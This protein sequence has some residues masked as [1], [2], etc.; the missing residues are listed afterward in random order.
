[1]GFHNSLKAEQAVLNSL[2][3]DNDSLY[4]ISGFLTPEDFST[5][6]YGKMFARAKE[7]IP[8]SKPFDVATLSSEGFLLSEII[9]LHDIVPTAANV[10]HYASLVKDYSRRRSLLSVASHIE[11]L[12]ESGASA[13]D[14]VREAEREILSIRNSVGEQGRARS[15]KDLSTELMEV[16]KKRMEEGGGFFGHRTGLQ[17]LDSLLGGMQDGETLIL[18]GRPSMGK[19]SVATQII[20]NRAMEGGRC[21]FHSLEMSHSMCVMR[22]LAQLSSLSMSRIKNGNVRGDNFE[23][24]SSAKQLLSSFPIWIDDTGAISV[25]NIRATA[26]RIAAEAGGLDLLVVD[27]L[28]LCGGNGRDGRERD[29]AEASAGLKAI[30]KE[31]SMPVIV[32]SQLNR[33][34]EMRDD[35]RPRL[36]D[37]RESGA[38]EQD[39]DGVVMV[40]RPGAYSH[41]VPEGDI[42]LIVRK[43]RNGPLGTAY[44]KWDPESMGVRNG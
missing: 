43:N 30:A 35:K 33:S 41:D 29:V 12:V 10:E 23:R 42:E 25:P 11:S 27:Y 31:F 14:C 9:D 3:L 1:M 8:E 22:M 38:I 28:Q 4:K 36:S 20:L 39:A 5:I 18:A 15:V 2:L 26:R 19:S 44:A 7:L 34:C 24:L 37:L 16:I 40:Y 6:T 32:L 21:L 17:E 13:D